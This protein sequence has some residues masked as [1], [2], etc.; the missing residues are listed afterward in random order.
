MDEEDESSEIKALELVFNSNTLPGSIT[1]WEETPENDTV[2]LVLNFENRRIKARDDNF[3]NALQTIRRQIEP[4]GYRL[5]CYGASLNV[6]PSNMSLDMGSGDKAYKLTLGQPA[7]S[8]DIVDIFDTGS[9]MV[10]ATV[11]KQEAFY[12]SWFNSLC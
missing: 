5:N 3:F 12:N 6:Y 11:D 2:L 10:L 4:E 1:L 8:T 7:K 9:D